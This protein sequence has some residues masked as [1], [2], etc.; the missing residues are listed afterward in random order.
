MWWYTRTFGRVT[1]DVWNGFE[2][3][4]SGN[5]PID[6]VHET[7]GLS[8]PVRRSSITLVMVTRRLPCNRGRVGGMRR[9]IGR[10]REGE[11]GGKRKGV[12]VRVRMRMRM[13]VSGKVG[14]GGDESR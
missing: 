8:T 11:I 14:E 4:V 9:G 13:R 6:P 10:V 2:M 12:R 7:F 5:F 1:L 3:S